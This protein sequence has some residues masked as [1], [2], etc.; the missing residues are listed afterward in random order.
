MRESTRRFVSLMIAL[1]MVLQII[2]PV[3]IAWATELS[4]GYITA[5]HTTNIENVD[6]D[7][8]V[9][10]SKSKEDDPT[11]VL[12]AYWD[13][14]NLYVGT[15]YT[16]AST[17]VITVNGVSKEYTLDINSASTV[18]TIPLSEVNVRLNDY[19]QCVEFNALL[20]SDTGSA[21]IADR[22]LC[23]TVAGT[24]IYDV[25][26]DS[27]ALEAG[28][29][30]G[31]KGSGTA[32]IDTT[33]GTASSYITK[34]TGDVVFPD[35]AD[36]L[37]TQTI[38]VE[39]M[40][41]TEAK[42]YGAENESSRARTAVGNGYSYIMIDRTINEGF[43]GNWGNTVSCTLHNVDNEGN[44]SL[45]VLTDI[46]APEKD[47][48]VP[49]GVKVGDTFKL[50]TYWRADN[51]VEIYV[52]GELKATVEDAVFLNNECMGG[53]TQSCVWLM[54]QCLSAGTTKMTVTNT[55]VYVPGYTSI[56]QE[57]TQ[58]VISE[59]VGNVEEVRYD[60]TH[61]MHIQQTIEIETMPEGTYT[62]NGTS[63][64]GGYSFYLG[65]RTDGDYNNN[66][67]LHGTIINTGDQNL[68]L[69]VADNSAA[70]Y[71][72]VD[73]G[74]K[75]GDKFVLG[76]QWNTDESLDIYV[77]GI[78]K[79]TIENVTRSVPGANNNLVLS[80]NRASD[81]SDAIKLTISNVVIHNKI[82]VS[83]ADELGMDSYFEAM[84]WNAVRND[85]TL[86]TFNAVNSEGTPYSYVGTW[87]K[88]LY[89]G[90]GVC[91]W[92]ADDVYT[93]KG[94]FVDGEFSPTPV[95]F[96][97]SKGTY[98]DESYTITNNAL[99]FLEKY[100]QIFTDNNVSNTEIEYEQNFQY[101]AFE[102]N[103]KKYG[104]KLIVVPSLRVVQIFENDYWGYEHTFIIAQDGSGNVYY[105]NLFGYWEN[106]YEGSYIKLTAL[107]LDYFTYPN[108]Y[109]DKIWAIACA[110]V[111]IN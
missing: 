72:A 104:S 111:R 56:T 105:V 80:Y 106:I 63:T 19:N 84:N 47:L 97:V 20:K 76:T 29:F 62:Y 13:K 18:V 87:K 54:H 24:L 25:L 30:A 94:T 33:D 99:T 103:P 4:T 48:V 93:Q 92:E 83:I 12:S 37:M 10:F 22:E 110:G 90:Y 34:L 32:V 69:F 89:N 55:A 74:R 2:P 71:T 91:H 38:C 28:D 52:D 68:T 82:P 77:D 35:D 57:I 3:P 88:G 7:Y 36:I 102:K 64:A 23:F 109:G 79:T 41:V 59:M 21:E 26:A 49:L 78:Y 1:V 8:Q 66:K 50:D 65:D 39:E 42:F 43:A 14:D 98:P 44:L 61:N 75:I 101:K 95:E 53:A 85:I 45:V 9:E 96:F 58:D 16:N 86:P 81:L 27:A 6:W 11:G 100:P 31:S 40:P 73:L 17:L 5:E 46:D 67:S 15:E 51:S 70:G 107:P 60:I 108:V